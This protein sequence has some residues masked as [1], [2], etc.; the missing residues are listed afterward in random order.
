[1]KRW[2]LALVLAGASLWLWAPGFSQ[3]DMVTVDTNPFERP[4][5][6]PA[7]FAHDSHN[8]KAGIDTCNEC[9]HV[10]RDGKKVED[11]SSEGERCADCHGRKAQ[12]RAPSLAT[13]FHTNCKGCHLEQ[14]K[15][16]VMCGQCHV[17]RPNA[18]GAAAK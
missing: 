14:R 1:M 11:E 13:A 6:A 5:R 15:G 3:E 18:A 9:H 16:P 10:Y 2:A 7:L 12:G 8:E 4:Q 17:W